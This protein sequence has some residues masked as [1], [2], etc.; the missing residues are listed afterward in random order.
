MKIGMKN[1]AIKLKKTGILGKQSQLLY[2]WARGKSLVLPG[3]VRVVRPT[4][5]G[6]T[7]SHLYRQ[8]RN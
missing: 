3:V 8:N 2:A 1:E 7:G 6:T 4:L 5:P